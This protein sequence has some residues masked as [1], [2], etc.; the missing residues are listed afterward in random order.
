M[1]HF[2]LIFIVSHDTVRLSWNK[3]PKM[4][5]LRSHLSMILFTFCISVHYSNSSCSARNTR[6]TDSFFRFSPQTRCLHD[7]VVTCRIILVWVP[8]ST[9][10]GDNSFFLEFWNSCSICIDFS[11]YLLWY[12][13]LIS[14]TRCLSNGIAPYQ[15]GVDMPI[16]VILL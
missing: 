16:K 5:R 14:G 13:H 11:S 6:I 3:H 8:G 4:G 12:R 2:T 15:V 7:T 1:L 9:P 10:G